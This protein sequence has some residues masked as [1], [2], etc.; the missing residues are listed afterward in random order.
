MPLPPQ[1]YPHHHP[2]D[3][4]ISQASTADWAASTAAEREVDECRER[5]SNGL[6]K[7]SVSSLFGSR[8]GTRQSASKSTPQSLA[9]TAAAAAASAAAYGT[10]FAGTPGGS[11]GAVEED[12]GM[13]RRRPKALPPHLAGLEAAGPSAGSSTG[14]AR[15]GSSGLSPAAGSATASPQGLLKSSGS[16]G[17]RFPAKKADS[18]AAGTGSSG[19]SLFGHRGGHAKE[20]SVGG[21]A[22]VGGRVSTSGIA[23]MANGRAADPDFPAMH[24]DGSVGEANRPGGVLFPPRMTR[25]ANLGLARTSAHSA[26]SAASSRSDHLAGMG[27]ANSEPATPAVQRRRASGTN[28]GTGPSPARRGRASSGGGAPGS[29]GWGSWLKGGLGL[30]RV[31]AQSAAAGATPGGLSGD[32]LLGSGAGAGAGHD[33]SALEEAIRGAEQLPELV[34]L[35]LDVLRERDEWRGRAVAAQEALGKAQAARSS[36]VREMQRLEVRVGRRQGGVQ[37]RGPQGRRG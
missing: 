29:G 27:M 5:S 6:R 19:F 13:F 30:G 1:Q 21:A 25:A 33:S 4:S 26:A 3:A 31:S 8:G 12:G 20:Q 10:P 35:A 24:S 32:V 18:G 34:G 15:T 2:R 16:V 28:L 23:A 9:P 37:G 7:L 14:A 36:A 22:V 11:G 17:S